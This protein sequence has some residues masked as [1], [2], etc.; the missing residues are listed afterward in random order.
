MKRTS[1]NAVMILIGVVVI[2][3]ALLYVFGTGTRTTYLD[4]SSGR[5]RE[6]WSAPLL[7]KR[8]SYHETPVSEFIDRTSIKIDPPEWR[9][10][11][12][13]TYFLWL[14][15]CYECG[16]GGGVVSEWRG[17]KYILK[18]SSF[19]DEEAVRLAKLF[20]KYMKSRVTFG[21]GDIYMETGLYGAFRNVDDLSD[22]ERLEKSER[23][24]S[25]LQE[26]EKMID[27][28]VEEREKR[29]RDRNRGS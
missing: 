6:E 5:V 28:E 15:T 1:K 25:F 22:S 19:T 26:C 21:L 3:G 14:P 12:S 8:T 20:V 24:N 13:S 11:G 4:L 9:W 2:L 7:P 17:W 23:F 18:E 16:S 29:G 10:C 27:A